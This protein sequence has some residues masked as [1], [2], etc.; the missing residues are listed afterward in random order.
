MTATAKDWVKKAELDFGTARREFMTDGCPNPDAV[1]FHCQQCIEKF[2]K[3]LLVQQQV[4]PPFTHDL[5]MLSRLLAKHYMDWESSL[6]DFDELTTLGTELRYPGKFATDDQV[7][8]A[9]SLCQKYRER[10]LA[11]V[12]WDE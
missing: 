5:S 7:I 10:L 2:M 4:T 9:F 8:R 6:D 1:C 3:A 11:F 12:K